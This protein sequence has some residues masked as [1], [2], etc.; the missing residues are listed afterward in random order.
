[1]TKLNKNNVPSAL[2]QIISVAE[3]WGINDDYDREKKISEATKSELHTLIASIDNVTDED[4]YGWLEGPES[5][6]ATPSEEYVSFTCLTMAIDSAK[7]KL[8]KFD[9]TQW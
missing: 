2:H 9:V 8:K 6:L 5:Y 4:L 7:I 3:E 1:M